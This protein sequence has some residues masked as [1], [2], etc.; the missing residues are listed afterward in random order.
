MALLKAYAKLECE[1][2]IGSINWD[3]SLTL[4]NKGIRLTWRPNYFE[5]RTLS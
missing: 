3:K 1:A 4:N 5:K 2:E